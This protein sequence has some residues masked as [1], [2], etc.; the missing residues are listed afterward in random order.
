M[1]VVI[2]LVYSVMGCFCFSYLFNCFTEFVIC[3]FMYSFKYLCVN[4]VLI[5]Y[6]FVFYLHTHL[7][8]FV[9]IYL[10]T[11]LCIDLRIYLLTYLLTYVVTY[12]LAY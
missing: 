7:F 10:R 5:L 11:Y 8:V 1:Y 2:Q 6:E 9:I 3:L 4:Y 12:V